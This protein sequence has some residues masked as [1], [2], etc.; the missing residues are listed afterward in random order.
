MQNDHGEDSTGQGQP[1]TA[2]GKQVDSSVSVPRI[3]STDL[4]IHATH[5]LLNTT[6][7]PGTVEGE[8][9]GGRG[10]REREREEYLY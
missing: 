3:T 5:Y 9:E 7:V 6:L 2:D 10:R 8:G 1:L 4:Q